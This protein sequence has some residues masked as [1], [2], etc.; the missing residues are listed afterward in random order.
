VTR[1]PVAVGDTLV[2]G[3]T[4]GVPAGVFV[5]VLVEDGVLV[6]DGEGLAV[7]VEDAEGLGEALGDAVAVEVGVVLQ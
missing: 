2:L 1:V 4:L 7:W 3:L 6:A 5:A